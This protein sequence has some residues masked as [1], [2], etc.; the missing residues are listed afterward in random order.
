MNF[1]P[2]RP[3]THHNQADADRSIRR[4]KQ[5]L[6]EG[7][8]YQAIADTL[9]AENLKTIRGKEWTAVN[10]RQVVH[11]L[12]IERPSWYGL[13]ADRANLNIQLVTA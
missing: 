12:R 7:L 2:Y 13:S 8:T 3:T 6:I 5:L 4:L 10:I 9:N 1:K 11:A